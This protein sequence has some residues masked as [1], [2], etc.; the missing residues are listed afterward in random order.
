MQKQETLQKAYQQLGLRLG[1][2]EQGHLTVGPLWI[3][4]FYGTE[5]KMSTADGIAIGKFYYNN[6][7]EVLLWYA[8]YACRHHHINKWTRSV[9]GRR[10]L[11]CYRNK[12]YFS[13]IP[14]LYRAAPWETGLKV[15]KRALDGLLWR[16]GGVPRYFEPQ[17]FSEIVTVKYEAP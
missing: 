13:R 1:R 2:H 6:L 4:A 9:S 11:R 8:F 12:G 7:Y 3:N 10:E 17:M 16:H 5:N 14:V 15:A